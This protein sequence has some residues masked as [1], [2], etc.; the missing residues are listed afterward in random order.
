MLILSLLALRII[1]YPTVGLTIGLVGHGWFLAGQIKDL[2]K[3]MKEYF[4]EMR[5]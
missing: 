4:K 2:R 5:S 3:E 1:G